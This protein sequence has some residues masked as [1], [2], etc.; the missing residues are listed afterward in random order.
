MC[1]L[2]TH[3]GYVQVTACAE[4]SEN[5]RHLIVYTFQL[6]HETYIVC[7]TVCQKAGATSNSEKIKPVVLAIIELQYSC[8]KASVIQSGSQSGMQ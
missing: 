7:T 2:H 6:V 1:V 4:I 3:K 5:H 8:L